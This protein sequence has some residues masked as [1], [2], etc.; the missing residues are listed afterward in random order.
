MSVYKDVFE[1]VVAKLGDD[2][3]AMGAAAWAHQKLSNR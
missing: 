3:G 2:A 1:V